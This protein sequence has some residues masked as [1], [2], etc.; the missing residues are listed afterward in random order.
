ML[1]QDGQFDVTK[2]SEPL[3]YG[4]TFNSAIVGVITT[5]VKGS[6][7][8]KSYDP[9]SVGLNANIGNQ[10]TVP[11]DTSDNAQKRAQMVI[12]QQ[13]PSNMSAN[14]PT[15]A[16]ASSEQYVL[17]AIKSVD[18]SNVVGV[19]RKA[20]DAMILLRTMSS[21]SSTGGI[22]Q[23]VSGGLT[24][25]LQSLSGTI[26]MSSVL[27]QL[28]AIS[29][30]LSAP[31]QYLLNEAIGG[32]LSGTGTGALSSASVS[33][34]S[35][36][37]SA[38]SAA[39][40]SNSVAAIA[41]TAAT[42]GG[43][44]LGLQV[45]SLAQTIASLPV[46][47]STTQTLNTGS[48]TVQTVIS[49]L[50]STVADQLATIPALTGS[51]N[52]EIANN[53]VSS[54]LFEIRQ[55]GLAQL[56][57]IILSAQASATDQG[58]QKILGTTLSGILGS[59]GTLI[60]NIAPAISTVLPEH[61]PRTVLNQSTM[62]TMLQNATKVMSL[63]RM[64]FNIANMFGSTM[65]EQAQSVAGSLASAVSSMP[66]GASLTSIISGVSIQSTRTK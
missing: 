32:M 34:A 9:G 28:N 19:V 20:L 39:V 55:L 5:T 65:S 46:G 64:A 59:V 24:G 13:Y 47:Q 25:A 48:A 63:G 26:G 18:P 36:L 11:S 57:A 40:S 56:S 2:R 50:D 22:A 27:N 37:S 66:V 49:I 42:I 61:V 43:P 8:K 1:E 33:A 35:A 54:I 3:T 17:Q 53:L 16:S 44:L 6:L 62:Q 4:N 12:S 15:S 58:L 52:V 31:S 23:M 30:T 7:L 41:N 60:P 45:S 14:N 29:P 21:V 38:I 10:G 51:E